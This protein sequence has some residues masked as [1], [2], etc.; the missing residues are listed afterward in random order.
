M[1]AGMRSEVAQPF[2]YLR[3]PLDDNN[4]LTTSCACARR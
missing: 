3:L 4:S 1:M 2:A